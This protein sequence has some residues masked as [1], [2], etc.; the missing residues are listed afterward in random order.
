MRRPR[1]A[2][3]IQGSTVVR[4]LV[5]WL[6]AVAVGCVASLN[7]RAITL[8][9]NDLVGYVVPG[10][11]AGDPN[12][13]ARLNYFI[14][15]NNTG[16]AVAPDANLYTLVM[17][18]NVPDPL[19]GPA[20]LG[21][22]IQTPNGLPVVIPASYQYL[23]AKFGDDSVFYW[24]G[25]QSGSLT[26]LFVPPGLTGGLGLSHVTLFNEISS[27]LPGVPDQGATVILLG[28]VFVALA[29]VRRRRPI[30]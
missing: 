7:V 9:A 12:E 28:A 8:T 1:F 16:T 22:K 14:A 13:T 10:T 6:A 25:G 11:P 29:A 3:N 15:L 26:S 18:S 5:R 19:P 17:G 20:V 23:M 24:L 27:N 4:C 21:P 2:M 30:D